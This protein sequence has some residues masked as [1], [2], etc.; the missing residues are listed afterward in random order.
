MEKSTDK[1]PTFLAGG[2]K[3][4]ELMR[5]FDWTQTNLGAPENWEQSLKT[6]VS[7]CLNSNFPI[8]LYW[9]KDLILLYNDAWSSIPGGKHPWALGR[10]AKEVWPDIWKDIEPDFKKAL[11]GQP[12]GSKDALLPMERHGFVEECYFDFTFT[13]VYG[14][15]GN[16]N[17][18]FNAVI[19]T[20]FRVISEQRNEFL[21]GLV[22]TLTNAK[23][24][25]QLIENQIAFFKQNNTS[26]S[27]AIS[28]AVQKDAITFLGSTI[29]NHENELDLKKPFPFKKI[30]DSEELFLIENIQDYFNTIP[31]GQWLENPK[32]AVA[33]L[34]KDSNGELTHLIVCGL[35]AR[36][37]YNEQYNS[38]LK[39]IQTQ[40]EKFLNTINALQEDKKRITALE[41]LDKAKTVFFSNISHEFRTPIT[42]VL[43]PLEEILN[44]KNSSL[45]ENEKQNLEATHRNAM[46]LLRLVNSLLDYSRIEGGR[47]SANYTLTDLVSFTKD[48]ASNFRPIIETA[49]L[50]FIIT[51]E[52]LINPVYVDNQMWEK[53]VFNL[54]SNAFKYTLQGSISLKIYSDTGFAVVE[55]EDTGVGI[56]KDELPKMFN[57]FYRAKNV[58]G[59]SFEGTGIGL[60]LVKELINLHGGI[61]E[62][63][64]VEGK[65]SLFR[66]KIPFGK[67]HLPLLQTIEENREIDNVISSSYI[68]ETSTFANYSDDLDKPSTSSGSH[69]HTVLIVDD[70]SDMRKHL[71][72][73]LKSRFNIHT[74]ADGLQA[75]QKVEVCQP[76]IIVSDIMMP[77]M[78]GIQLVNEIKKSMQTRSIPVILVTARAGEES[79]MEGLK[80]GADDYLIK[81]F[82]ANELLSRISSQIDISKKR[83]EIEKRLKGFLKQ[84]PA[85]IALL[86]GKDFVYTFAN[87]LYQKMYSRS[88]K[89]L[90]GKSA[91]EVFPELAGQGIFELFDAIFESGEP[92]A[93]RE[94]P[95][96]LIENGEVKTHYYDFVLH[97]LKNNS[98]I[99]TDM[100]IHAYDITESVLLRKSIEES[101]SK[102]KILIETLP[103]MVWVTDA[104]GIQQ[105]VSVRWNEYTGMQPKGQETWNAILHPDDRDFVAAQWN[106]SLQNGKP[107]NIEVRLKDK[108]NRYR[109]HA[110]N[111]IPVLD[112]QNNITHWIGSFTD[113][114]TQKE[115][116]ENLEENVKERTK[117]LVQTNIELNNL[118]SSLQQLIDSSVEFISLID[119]DFNYL[120]VNKRF[121]T[122]IGI[123]RKD[124]VGKH[125]FE[126]NPKAKN[127]AQLEYIHNA[128][129][130]VTGH[131]SKRN[132]LAIDHIIIDTYFVPYYVQEKIEGVII[133][134]RD[135]TDIFK[136]E[137]QLEAK[138]KELEKMNKE[139][140]SFN[141][142]ASHDL[143]E[144]LRKIQAFINMLEN[145][146]DNQ[147]KREKY[148]EKI[149][150]SANRMSNLIRSILNYNSLSAGNQN[151]EMV[152][153]NA[154]ITGIENDYELILADKQATI[155]VIGS[156]KINAIPSQISQLFSNLISNSLKFSERPP[157]ITIEFSQQFS[158]VLGK[159][160]LIINFSDNGIGFEAEYKT[161]VFELFQRLHPIAV[162]PGSGIGLSTVK[163]IVENHHGLINVD[164]EIGK[165][166][167]FQI[168]LPLR[169]GINLKGF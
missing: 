33:I 97:P 148:I 1:S 93:R 88:E 2:G 150:S 25:N 54:L 39:T 52:E 58:V 128:L 139:L 117:Q 8:A 106:E 21:I 80:T 138:N 107:Y 163:R 92:F 17:G 71:K 143:Q 47:Q 125:L 115:F 42:L 4:G 152:N 79:R 12:G 99:V 108:Y 40:T 155:K 141:Y 19:E 121:E 118:Q 87:P 74:A 85:A 9:G 72:S 32:E 22:G 144:P 116:A 149:N 11:K 147:E 96:S 55:I 6:S 60:S 90:I 169:Q 3:M 46:R 24:S 30:M 158:E 63:E 105:F 78:D 49:K 120:M 113:I 156:A 161:K 98:G 68:S 153:L 77:V 48:L 81:P 127:S 130:G 26:V 137:L 154:L 5:Q 122:S 62:V 126:I 38:F 164:S 36:L 56:P 102:F 89:Q 112:S 65:G 45:N 160:S 31:K 16:V 82:S 73:L 50:K 142:V 84:A 67:E 110:G 57:R 29:S 41:E 27:F 34:I 104:R 166:S 119:K 61:I 111:G 103:Q 136:S 75:L 64:S 15:T 14:D 13:P 162:Y 124:I 28:Y 134:A 114:Q 165:G 37:R 132:S 70:N 76:D 94:F 168:I 140:E 151:F 59:R 101:E 109:W 66:V 91:K 100:M 133:M 129:K 35:N 51:A 20:S 123:N 53:I 7:I 135:V 83:T 157:I 145:N 44:S 159:E 18:V 131:L 95:A 23:T 43:G 86:E 167:T 69:E 10:T 146:L